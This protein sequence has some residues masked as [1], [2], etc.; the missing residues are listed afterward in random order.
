MSPQRSPRPASSYAGISRVGISCASI[1]SGLAL[2][3][4][5]ARILG[6]EDADCDPTYSRDCVS[7][8]TANANGGSSNDPSQLIPGLNPGASGSG[9]AAGAGGGTSSA[10]AGGD[11]AGGGATGSTE[12]SAGAA[13]SA[14]M[15]NPIVA[16]ASPL[17]RDYC[18]TLAANCTGEN[19]QYASPLACLAVCELLEPGTPGVTS[20]NN[21]QCRL[22]LAD[23]AASTGE[24]GES[25]YAAGPGGAGMCGSDCEGFCTMMTKKCTELG[26]QAQ[27]LQACAAVPDLSRPP[28]N[29]RYD[30][31]LQTGNSLQ[32]RL[33]HVSAASIEP[34][35]HCAHAAG[36]SICN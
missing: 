6:I 5:C 15:P 17:C 36:Q 8:E 27:C 4:G 14:D 18:D 26:T 13:G 32:C 2:A 3:G 10:G 9:G 11:G 7:D 28:T 22:S 24:P 1:L 35:T 29:Q 21:V 23:L 25:C 16:R 12:A 20:G 19:Q 34:A 33:F 30:S 31:S